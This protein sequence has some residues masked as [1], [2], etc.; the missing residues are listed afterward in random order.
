M[1]RVLKSLCVGLTGMGFGIILTLAYKLRQ[2]FYP[3]NLYLHN[4]RHKYFPGTLPVFTMRYIT[5]S[6]IEEFRA[7]C[8]TCGKFE[9]DAKHPLRNHSARVTQKCTS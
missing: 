8:A 6:D 7:Y 5:N 3:P 1:N 4:I 9:H 2:E